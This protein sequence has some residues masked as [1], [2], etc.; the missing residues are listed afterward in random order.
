MVNSYDIQRT[1][2]ERRGRKAA[3]DPI[4]PNRRALL[5][6]YSRVPFLVHRVEQLETTIQA[7]LSDSGITLGQCQFLLILDALGTVSQADLVRWSGCDASTTSL[8]LE[9]LA[10]RG[11]VRRRTDSADRRRKL[12]EISARGRRSLAAAMPVLREVSRLLLQSISGATRE[13]VTLLRR[14][15]QAPQYGP[16]SVEASASAVP[17][18]AAAL[19]PLLASPVFVVR[20]TLQVVDAISGEELTG[21]DATIRQFAAMLLI[22][23]HP[24]ICA[25]D[26]A[27]LGGFEASNVSFML[28]LLCRKSFVERY[29]PGSAGRVGYRITATGLAIVERAEP[30]MLRAERRLLGPLTSSEASRLRQLLARIVAG[31]AG[32]RFSKMPF[33]ANITSDREWLLLASRRAHAPVARLALGSMRGSGPPAFDAPGAGRST[34]A[35]RTVPHL[36][37]WCA[38]RI[39]QQL[40]R[41]LARHHLVL[42]EYVLIDLLAGGSTVDPVRLE[43]AL[44][45]S[46]RRL[47]KTV[48]SLREK[49]FATSI[50]DNGAGP[51]GGLAITVAG[52]RVRD[53][54]SRN[55]VRFER[56]AL[57]RLSARERTRMRSTLVA[58][59]SQPGLP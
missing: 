54:V 2:G 39:R 37:V 22:L 59:L 43:A 52:R 4:E 20:R 47:A 30:A 33:F 23:A 42:D 40:D 18:D 51:K 46:E 35:G 6:L 5:H 29:A 21:V 28:Q 58:F 13:F 44:G 55:L 11:D 31:A 53:A 14:I 24:G 15:A 17:A 16:V 57:A 12:V 34:Y 7:T 9:N 50:R 49:G 48:R 19:Q 27:R 26:L 3:P 1:V 38:L 25:A 10:Q 32:G 56:Q 36:I 45:A 8:V 41:L